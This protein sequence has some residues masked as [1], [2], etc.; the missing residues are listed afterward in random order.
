[1]LII[2]IVTL[3]QAEVSGSVHTEDENRPDFQLKRYDFFGHGEE[4]VYLLRHFN[5]SEFYFV[6]LHHNF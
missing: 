4:L 2:Y 1:M 5:K 6:W 3:L